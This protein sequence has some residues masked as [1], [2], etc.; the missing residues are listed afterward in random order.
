MGSKRTYETFREILTNNRDIEKIF[1]DFCEF[2]T[3]NVSKPEE[4]GSLSFDINP[5]NYNEYIE[6]CISKCI[7]DKSRSVIISYISKLVQ[8]GL[9]RFVVDEPFTLDNSDDASDKERYEYYCKLNHPNEKS[10]LILTGNS[11]RSMSEKGCSGRLYYWK[12]LTELEE[13][14]HNEILEKEFSEAFLQSVHKAIDPDIIKI[15]NTASET[16]RKLREI[17]KQMEQGTIKNIEI[18]SIFIA[19]ITLFLSNV[20]GASNYVSFGLRGI[21]AINISTL[22]SIEFLLSITEIFIVKKPLPKYAIGI[23]LA[24]MAVLFA[25]ILIVIFFLD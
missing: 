13:K 21:L 2:T 10:E 15:K 14:E 1:H 19:I 25:F 11:N 7:I 23:I 16:E 22:I 12:Y 17:E 5:V 4:Y 20:F 8:Y 6:H 3:Y 18:L 9:I 24:T